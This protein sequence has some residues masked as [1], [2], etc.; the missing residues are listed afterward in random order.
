MKTIDH[1]SDTVYHE[2]CNKYPKILEVIARAI[3]FH[4]RQ[5]LALRGHKETL[6]ESDENQNL[7]N[8]LT[9]LKELQNY[10]PELKEHLEAPQSKSVT[11]LSPTSQNEMIEVIGKKIIL[12]DIAEKKKKIRFL[13]CF[14]R[15]SNF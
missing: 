1:H 11:Y 2:R 14:C 9:Y 7:R 3:H 6:Q 13:Q 8:F 12:R 4:G 10:C 5:G 15:R